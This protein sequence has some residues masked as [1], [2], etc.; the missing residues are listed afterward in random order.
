MIEDEK[1]K[2]LVTFRPS[3]KRGYI[4]AGRTIGEAALELGVDLENICG[5]RLCYPV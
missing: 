5:G 4:E 1:D 2:Y 3:G